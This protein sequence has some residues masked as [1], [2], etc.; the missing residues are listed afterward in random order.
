MG[1]FIFLIIVFL[2]VGLSILGIYL[3]YRKKT[4]VDRFA[5]SNP[6]VSWIWY[7]GPK[8]GVLLFNEVEDQRG[9]EFTSIDGRRGLVVLPGSVQV[10][11]SYYNSE[12]IKGTNFTQT[13]QFTALP[14][15]NYFL[16]VD[17][18]N[19]IMRVLAQ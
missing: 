16:Q 18:V 5:A 8:S 4:R 15:K 19:R 6:T 12:D 9:M 11:I 2:L 13:L 7:S 1:S 17:E 3:N 14:E 10:Q